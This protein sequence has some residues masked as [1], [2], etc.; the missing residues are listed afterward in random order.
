MDSTFEAAVAEV[1]RATVAGDIVT[2]GEVASEA[3]YPGRARAVA[4][5]LRVVGD[6]PWWRVVPAS[7]KLAAPVAER[8]ARHLRAEGVQVTD[9]WRIRAMPPVNNAGDD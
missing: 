5:V 1:V 2:Y 9:D 6:L 7:G 4:R 8:Q 3:G